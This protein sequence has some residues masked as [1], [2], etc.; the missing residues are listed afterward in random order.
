MAAPGCA[1]GG[2]AEAKDDIGVQER[3]AG[4]GTSRIGVRPMTRAGRLALWRVASDAVGDELGARLP[5]LHARLDEHV[6]RHG[7]SA[8]NGLMEGAAVIHLAFLIAAS[9]TTPVLRWDTCLLL[10]G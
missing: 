4:T 5:F 2:G 1:I 9:A 10:A 7:L 3:F 8:D 6:R